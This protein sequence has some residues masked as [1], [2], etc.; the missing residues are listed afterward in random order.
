MLMNKVLLSSRSHARLWAKED[1]DEQ[2]DRERKNN[3][4]LY[5]I[6]NEEL[7]TANNV[8]MPKTERKSY[9]HLAFSSATIIVIVAFIWF[10]S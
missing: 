2:K 4:E 5:L 9:I 10:I 8:I 6:S 1:E 7:G 3:T